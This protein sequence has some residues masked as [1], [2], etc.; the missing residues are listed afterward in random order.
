MKIKSGSG[1]VLVVLIISISFAPSSFAV[2][3]G[4]GRPISGMQIAPYAG[5]DMGD[6]IRHRRSRH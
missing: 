4:L 1:G 2:E 6:G 3:G 5:P